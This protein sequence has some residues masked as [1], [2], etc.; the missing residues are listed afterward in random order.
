[1]DE[2]G[3]STLGGSIR[4]VSANDGTIVSINGVN[5]PVDPLVCTSPLL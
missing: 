1:M 3:V 4:P 5:D 2:G